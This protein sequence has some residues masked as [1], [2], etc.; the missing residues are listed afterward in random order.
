M[1]KVKLESMV[2]E[3]GGSMD[4]LVH[5]NRLGTQCA[6]RH[7]IPANPDTELQKINRKAFADAVKEWQNLTE[8]E[9]KFWNKKAVK[10]RSKGK[11]GKTGYSVFLSACLTNPVRRG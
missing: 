6:R 9:K 1:A 11:T 4:K 10:L 3:A 2:K 5:Y 8:D 7:V